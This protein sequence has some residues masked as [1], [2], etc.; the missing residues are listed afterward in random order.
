M[1]QRIVRW[2]K[3]HRTL[4]AVSKIISAYVSLPE[5]V[6]AFR[7]RHKNLFRRTIEN[8]II[9]KKIKNNERFPSSKINFPKRRIPHVLILCSYYRPGSIEKTEREISS[10]KYNVIKSKINHV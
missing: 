7:K 10:E 4:Y 2:I 5:S 1:K 3:K 6:R 9:I 8:H